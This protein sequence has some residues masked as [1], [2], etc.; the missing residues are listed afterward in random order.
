[1][2]FSTPLNQRGDFITVTMAVP[3]HGAMC[4]DDTGIKTGGHV[5]FLEHSVYTLY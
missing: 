1:M 3:I 4:T 2:S 5:T